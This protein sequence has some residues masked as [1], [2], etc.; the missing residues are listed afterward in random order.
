MAYWLMKTEPETF[1]IEDLERRI[2]EPWDGIRN[3][4]ARNF[5]R[6]DMRLGDGVLIYHSRIPSPAVVGLATIAS[7]AYPDPT[8][9]DPDSPYY[10]G[11]SNPEE[12]RWLL[13]EVQFS[14]RWAKG[15]SLTVIKAHPLLRN[16]MV[17]QRGCRL[18]IQP[19]SQ[20][21]WD[22]LVALGRFE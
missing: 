5:I 21:H 18:S 10:D 11:R 6:D 15:I 3:Y 13:R 22:V 17:A 9:F 12:P 8:Q 16:M 1:S 19:V 20:D 7:E 2:I 4:Q 14:E